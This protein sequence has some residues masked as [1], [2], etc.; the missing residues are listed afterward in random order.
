MPWASAPAC[1]HV[2]LGHQFSVRCSLGVE[3]FVL[4]HELP[5]Q[6]K[7]LLLQQCDPF[8]KGVNAGR[9]AQAGSRRI[10]SPG[11]SE[12]GVADAVDAGGYGSAAGGPR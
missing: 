1:G 4:V 3:L 12:S 6:V 8:L 5:L 11:A 7:D 9:A 10:C 2:P